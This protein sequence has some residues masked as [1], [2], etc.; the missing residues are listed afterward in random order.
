MKATVTES[1]FTDMMT[2]FITFL[3]ER[4]D[5]PQPNAMRHQSFLDGVCLGQRE[6]CKRFDDIIRKAFDAAERKHANGELDFIETLL[7]KFFTDLYEQSQLYEKDKPGDE[8]Y[9][10]EAGYI[11]GTSLIKAK[12]RS[13]L[14]RHMTIE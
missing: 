7:A 11:T 1:Q 9:S 13:I 12:A 8:D 4:R 2:E 10:Y 14:T 6:E 3:S 5:E